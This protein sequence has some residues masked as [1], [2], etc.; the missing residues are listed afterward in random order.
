M[1]LGKKPVSCIPCAKRKVKCDRLQPCCHCRRRPNDQC[2]YPTSSET[3]NSQLES[4]AERIR[5]L[6]QYV[7]KLGGD[8]GHTPEVAVDE[9]GDSAMHQNGIQAEANTTGGTRRQAEKLR[10]RPKEAPK[11]T[12]PNDHGAS[13]LISQEDGE[14]YIES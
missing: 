2:V 14:N 1:R 12:N 11:R 5:Q 8:L 3:S 10:S 13:K 7:Q 4:Q 9:N 6:E